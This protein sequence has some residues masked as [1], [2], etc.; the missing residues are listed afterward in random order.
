V[1]HADHHPAEHTVGAVL[2]LCLLTDAEDTHRR[3]CAARE[4][5]T[6]GVHPSA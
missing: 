5:A 4:G 1:A 6:Q 2:Q 3:A